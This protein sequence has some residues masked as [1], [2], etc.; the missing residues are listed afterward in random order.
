MFRVFV[1]VWSVDHANCVKNVL[2]VLD[3]LVE[4]AVGANSMLVALQF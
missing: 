3:I 1:L 4:I 2:V